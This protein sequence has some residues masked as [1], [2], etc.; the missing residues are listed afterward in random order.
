MT[1]LENIDEKG[2]TYPI[3]ENQQGNPFQAQNPFKTKR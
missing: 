1:G 3:S 2:A